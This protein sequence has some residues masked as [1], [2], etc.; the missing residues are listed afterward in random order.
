MTDIADPFRERE[1]LTETR[2][3]YVLGADV[4][5]RSNDRRL[6][7]LAVHAFGGLP[8]HRWRRTRCALRIQLRL[9]PRASKTRAVPPAPRF[10]SGVECLVATVDADNFAIVDPG[11]HAAVVQVSSDML[12]H[13]Y[14]VRYELIEFAAI[15]LATRA[16]SLLPLHAACVGR[17]GRGLLLLGDSGAGK[18]SFVLAAA[19][20]GLELLAE[21]SVF[22]HPAERRATGVAAFVHVRPSGVR[23]VRSARVRARIERAPMIRRRSGALKRELDIRHGLASLAPRPFEI[24][25]MLVLSPGRSKAASQLRCITPDA[26]ARLLRRLQP[27]AAR[28]QDWPELEGHLARVGAYRL[29]RGPKIEDSVRAACALL[30]PPRA[31]AW[32]EP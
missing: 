6:L 4:E 7:A 10:T 32:R 26:H 28:H 16:Q 18:S 13:P 23:L 29:L 31:P 11:R 2:T 17:R 19:L 8:R 20:Q 14:H 22:V 24:V 1:R 27:Y 30:P 21:D 25:A 12:A 3:L 9:V 5:F 15:T